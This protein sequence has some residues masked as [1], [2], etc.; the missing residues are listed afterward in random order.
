VKSKQKEKA[1]SRGEG[2]ERKTRGFGEGAP[3]GRAVA[4]VCTLGL[5]RAARCGSLLEQHGLA[6]SGGGACGVREG[7]TV[8][9]ETRFLGGVPCSTSNN[10]GTSD[11]AEAALAVRS[12]AAA[13]EAGSA[14]APAHA[15][16][17]ADAAASAAAKTEEEARA[18]RVERCNITV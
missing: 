15:R 14:Q 17:E 7:T 10:Q 13:A 18:A 4:R 1:E 5:W 2:E 16:F 8:I 12:G 6:A 3:E 11:Q 9:S